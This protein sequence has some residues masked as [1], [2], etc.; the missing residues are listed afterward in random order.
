MLRAN[1]SLTLL[2]LSCNDLNS[3]AAAAIADAVLVGSAPLLTL[4][5]AHNRCVMRYSVDA[6]LLQCVSHVSV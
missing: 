4:N 3:A 2:D 6:A 5:L 1:R